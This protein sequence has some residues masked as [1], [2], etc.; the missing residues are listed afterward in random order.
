MC[1]VCMNKLRYKISVPIMFE[2]LDLVPCVRECGLL[3]NNKIVDSF[4]M[5]VFVV[6]IEILTNS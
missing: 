4:E 1:I 2:A 6:W 3:V 5:K